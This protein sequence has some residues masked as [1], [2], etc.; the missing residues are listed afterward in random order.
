MRRF[1]LIGKSLSHSFSQG[2]FTQKFQREGI[3]DCRYDL[4]PLDT[5]GQLPGLFQQYPALEGI[6]ITIPYKHEVLAYASDLSHLPPGMMAAN[7]LR[8][9]NG[10][11]QAFNTDVFGFEQSF[12]QYYQP[13][14]HSAALVLGNGGAA[15]AVQHVLRSMHIPFKVVGRS[16]AGGIQLLYKQVDAAIA[17]SHPIWIN[18]TPLG[19]A[20]NVWEKP[21]MPYE[22]LTPNHYCYDLVYNPAETAFLQEAKSHGA[23]AKNGYDMLVLQAEKSWE[24]WNS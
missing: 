18:T 5:I 16:E 23:A 15:Q 9:R 14:R 2:Y 4:F 13:N 22:C 12:H 19:T 17:A 1:G 8:R 6:N 21:E 3:P 11:W 24:I 7:C 10:V 20:P